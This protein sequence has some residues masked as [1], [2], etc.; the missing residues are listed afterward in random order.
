MF[1]GILLV[2]K[3]KDWTSHDVVAKV[4]GMVKHEAGRK[5]KVGHTGTL[6]PLAKGLMILVIGAYCKRAEEFSKLDKIYEVEM[7]LGETS[8][9]GDSEGEIT[10]TDNKQFQKPDDRQINETILGF[11]GQI[12]Q[13]PPAFSAIKIGG[14]KAYDLARAGKEVK[15]EPRQVTV[16]EI[17][18]ITHD[19]PHV[20]FTAHV[21]SGTYIRS[22]VADIGERLL[23][24]AYMTDLKRTKVGVFSLADAST[25]EELQ[26][27]TLSEKLTLPL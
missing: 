15:L 8:T 12:E 9:T 1:D 2:N 4:R 26:S 19:Y 22:L 17:S 6:D 21:S 16:H 5:V 14:K 25:I 24:G 20:S 10:K 18:D 27:T 7:K 13:V 11:R 23:T 3:E